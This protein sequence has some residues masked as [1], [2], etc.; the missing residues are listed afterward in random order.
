VKKPRL[1]RLLRHFC[2]VA[3]PVSLFFAVTGEAYH[4]GSG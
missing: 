1:A 2:R 3:K 4:V